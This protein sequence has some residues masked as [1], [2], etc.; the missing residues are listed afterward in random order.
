LHPGVA[1]DRSPVPEGHAFGVTAKASDVKVRLY[2]KLIVINHP[3]VSDGDIGESTSAIAIGSFPAGDQRARVPFK[4]EAAWRA[5]YTQYR[6]AG[7][8]SK[9]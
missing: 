4:G 5:F 2:Q 9:P 7:A 3:C 6:V 1:G 8:S